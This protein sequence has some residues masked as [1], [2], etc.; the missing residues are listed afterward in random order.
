MLENYTNIKEV[1]KDINKVRLNNRDRWNFVI[2]YFEGVRIEIKLF[3][4][5]VQ[6]LNINGIK[7]SNC[8]GANITDFK[9]YLS[10]T[11]IKGVENV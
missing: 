9:K 2:F 8:M 3:N 1:I 10:D 6:I 11:I 7:Y 5:W 4:T